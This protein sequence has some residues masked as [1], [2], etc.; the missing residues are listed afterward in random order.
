MMKFSTLIIMTLAG[1]AS[2]ALLVQADEGFKDLMENTLDG[3]PFQHEMESFE[4]AY[5]V[6]ERE[7]CIP[8]GKPCR[9][10]PCCDNRNCVGHVV[11]FGVVTACV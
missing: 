6:K 10:T 4:G 8:K 7:N 3:M 5:D 11:F 1:I 9:H 2:L